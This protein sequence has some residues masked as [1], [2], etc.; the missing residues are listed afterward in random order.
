M[1]FIPFHDSN[2]LVHI[3]R[4]YVAW[5]ILLI[6]VAVFFLV[7]SGNLAGVSVASVGSFGLIPSAFN[8]LEE[9]PAL[10]PDFLTLMTYA[11]LHGDVW[12]LAGNMIFLWVLADNIED[13]LG[14]VRFIVFYLLCAATAGYTYVLTDPSSPAPVIGSSGAIAGIV[15]AYFILHPR[16]KM[17]VLLFARIPVR[18]RAMWVLGFWIVFQVLA[19]FGGSAD[20]QVAWS[21]HVGGLAAGAVLIVIMR[22]RGVTLFDRGLAPAAAAAP[23]KVGPTGDPSRIARPPSPR[24]GPGRPPGGGPWG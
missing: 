21:S 12:H 1:A 24:S 9:S 16:A 23:G 19:A 18:L 2:P 8:G 15:S 4:P 5:A 20:D 13:A 22:R 14:H 7:Q 6:N 17:W 3:K 11:F 10:V